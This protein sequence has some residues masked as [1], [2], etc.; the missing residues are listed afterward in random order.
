M[1]KTNLNHC[2]KLVRV[3]AVLVLLVAAVA[4]AM[5]VSVSDDD[6]PATG[7]VGTEVT[8]T[9]TL[10]ELY[11][12]Y[13]GWKLAGE[14]GLQNVTWTVTYYDQAG[15]QVSQESY[16]GQTFNGS[17]VSIDDG[18]DEVR[19]RVTGTVPAVESY[20]YEPQAEFR[21]VALR[22]VRDGGNSNGIVA[23]N[24]TH[25]TTESREA[26]RAL[27]AAAAAI[28]AAG[29]PTKAQ[30]SFDIA[31]NAYEAGNFDNAVTAAER[32]EREA[33]QASSTK[34]RN[35]YILFGL[36]GL[37]GVGAVIGGVFFWRS[38]RDTYDKLG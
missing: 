24:A 9:M 3:L 20:T 17:A 11:S 32:A 25:Y 28:E 8:A 5:A 18:T 2:S 13:D 4:P 37:F 29:T 38:Q 26:R 33:K 16:D 7:E 36:V 12:E 19:V 14:T 30:E 23:R 6:V 10:T 1:T 34:Q 35:R 31:V 15:N 22:Q 27:D 21:L